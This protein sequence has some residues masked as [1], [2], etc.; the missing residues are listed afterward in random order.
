MAVAITD[1]QAARMWTLTTGVSKLVRDGNRDPEEVL[2]VLQAIK[3]EKDGARKLLDNLAAASVGLAL[4]RI[5]VWRTLTIGGYSREELLQMFEVE[6]FRLSAWARD[7]MERPEFTTSDRPYTIRLGRVR[8]G[9]LGFTES[10]R[11]SELFERLAQHFDECPPETGPHLR[12][13]YR[14]QPMNEWLSVC[15][16]PIVA[17]VGAPFVFGLEADSD[18]LGL[19]AHGAGPES[20]WDPGYELVVRLRE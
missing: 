11:T 19:L 15:Q 3:N 12:R 5:P 14:D 16:K 18:G 1:R 6:K 10:P 9:D 20:G 7:L 17:S 8:V 4:V 13:I 2:A